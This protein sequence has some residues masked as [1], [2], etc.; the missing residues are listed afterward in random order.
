MYSECITPS[1]TM[2]ASS[3]VGRRSQ[4]I[5][6]NRNLSHARSANYSP[7]ANISPLMA[8]NFNSSSLRRSVQTNT[9][10]HIDVCVFAAHECS[11]LHTKS[12]ASSLLR[13]FVLIVTCGQ[14]TTCERIRVILCAGGLCA[15]VRLR[16]KFMQQ[17]ILSLEHLLNVAALSAVCCTNRMGRLCE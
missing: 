6:F 7:F 1:T 16:T 10:T 2:R 5:C 17:L 8:I 12:D 15:I 14:W 9:L 4:F 11:R 13:L 3:V